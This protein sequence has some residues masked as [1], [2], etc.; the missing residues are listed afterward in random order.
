MTRIAVEE[1][2][3]EESRSGVLFQPANNRPFLY[4]PPV[5]DVDGHP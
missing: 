1:G 2:R 5:S 4:F 3:T